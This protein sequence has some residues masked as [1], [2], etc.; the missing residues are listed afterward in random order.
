MRPQDLFNELQ[1]QFGQFMPDMAKAARDD[2]EQHARAVVASMI[3][4]LDLVTR[5]EFDA[6]AA[7]L[8]RTRERL[9]VLEKRVAMLEAQAGG[10]Q[11]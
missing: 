5:E 1:Q 10:K 4:R 7:V 3:N 9:E 2:M 11:D 6:Q 8:L